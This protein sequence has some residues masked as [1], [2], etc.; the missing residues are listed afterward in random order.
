M[1]ILHD[2]PAGLIDQDSGRSLPP[3]GGLLMALGISVVF[4]GTLV[5][6]VL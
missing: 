5:W 6:A 2:V 1:R 4:W 3:G